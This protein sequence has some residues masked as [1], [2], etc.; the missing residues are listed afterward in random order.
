MLLLIAD[1]SYAWL[2]YE[3]YAVGDLVERAISVGRR[4]GGVSP[5]DGFSPYARIVNGLSQASAREAQSVGLETSPCTLNL[6]SRF[7]NVTGSYQYVSLLFDGKVSQMRLEEVV[8]RLS[9]FCMQRPGGK[10]LEMV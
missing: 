2:R 3:S 6:R 7:N 10:H 9:G 5:S 1:T 4:A 8:G